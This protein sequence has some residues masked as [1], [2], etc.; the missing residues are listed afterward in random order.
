MI[1]ESIRT[2]KGDVNDH[3]SEEQLTNIRNLLIEIAKDQSSYPKRAK[4]NSIIDLSLED[5]FV[6]EDNA[7]YFVSNRM[8]RGNTRHDTTFYLKAIAS[9]QKSGHPFDL[10]NMHGVWNLTHASEYAVGFNDSTQDFKLLRILLESLICI[11]KGE[12]PQSMM[13]IKQMWGAFYRWSSLLNDNYFIE[14]IQAM[15]QSKLYGEK[16]YIEEYAVGQWYI[17]HAADRLMDHPAFRVLTSLHLKEYPKTSAL[18]TM[19]LGGVLTLD[20][21]YEIIDHRCLQRRNNKN[22]SI[23]EWQRT[24]LNPITMRHYQENTSSIVRQWIHDSVVREKL[25]EQ[26]YYYLYS[27]ND[28]IKIADRFT[29][30]SRLRK[31]LS[32]YKISDTVASHIKQRINIV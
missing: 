9:I 19:Y 2:F 28:L 30:K 6:N 1:T 17:P 14:L 32:I 3:A 29:D 13:S 8:N 11:H 31:M 25:Y 26:V 10:K 5:R 15:G 20:R 27:D 4:P 22:G 7:G 24:V 12:T 16:K 18:D 21:C 23:G